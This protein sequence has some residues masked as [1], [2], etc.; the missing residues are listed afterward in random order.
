MDKLP[1]RSTKTLKPLLLLLFR[2]LIVKTDMFFRQKVFL[3]G[4][5]QHKQV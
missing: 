3:R 1:I 4:D 2:E 5:A